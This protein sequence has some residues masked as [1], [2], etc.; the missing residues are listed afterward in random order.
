M[1]DMMY[2]KAVKARNASYAPYSGFFVGASVLTDTGELFAGCNLENAAYGSTQCAEA[3]AIGSMVAAARTKVIAT[4]IVTDTPDGILPC[5]NCLQ[6]LTELGSQD[7]RIYICNLKG[8]R[9]ETTLG[10]M[11]PQGF[12]Q[13]ALKS[14]HANTPKGGPAVVSQ[15]PA[16]V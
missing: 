9:R 3:N 5:G 8:L 2:E 10:K 7:T 14:Q 12:D 13:A 6:I 4:L 1:F 16:A 11:L 15:S